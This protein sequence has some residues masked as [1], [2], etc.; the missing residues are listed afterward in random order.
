LQIPYSKCK[1]FHGAP[2]KGIFDRQAKAEIGPWGRSWV[3]AAE[4]IAST[5]GMKRPKCQI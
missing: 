4:E 2:E 5:E 1:I 3:A